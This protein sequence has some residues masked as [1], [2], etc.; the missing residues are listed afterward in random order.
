MY[1]AV[2]RG[3]QKNADGTVTIKVEFVDDRTDK[4]LRF[5]TYTATSLQVVQEQISR[6][7]RSLVAAE[8]DTALSTAV[9]GQILGSI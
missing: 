2:G 7:L 4:M 8:S 1:H 6:D 9:V 3:A 5:E